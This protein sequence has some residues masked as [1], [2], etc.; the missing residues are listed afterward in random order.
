MT[1]DE[2]IRQ[3]RGLYSGKL[4]QNRR[5]AGIPDHLAMP[6]WAETYWLGKQVVKGPMDLWV[7]QEIIFETRPEVLLETGTSGGGSAFFFATLFDI[8]GRGAVITVD[9]D[10]YPH[11]WREHP[12]ITYLVGD[13]V[14][15]VIAQRMRADSEGRVTMVSL[16]SLHTREHVA[17]ELAV[18]A[19]F[20]SAGQYLVV[21]DVAQGIHDGDLTWGSGAALAFMNAQPAFVRDATREKHLMTSNLWLRRV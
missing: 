15:D 14:S 11:L 3:F 7:S 12:R 16:D 19:P 5:A 17:K 8:L 21:E 2:V 9:K 13:S 20:V 6:P 18:Y 1:D 4:A 10:E